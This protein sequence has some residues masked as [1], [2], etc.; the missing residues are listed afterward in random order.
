MKRILEACNGR[1]TICR[2]GYT[3]SDGERLLQ[4]LTLLLMMM[5]MV[6]IGLGQGLLLVS[7]FHMMRITIISIEIRACLAKVWE[8]MLWVGHWTKSPNHLLHTGLKVENFLCDSLS[9]Q[10][11]CTMVERTP[12]SMWATSTKEWLFSPRMKPWCVR[13]SHP[14]WGL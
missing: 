12:W 10:S 6:A 1:L 11:P 14:I 8:I 7:L 5:R 4:A 9:Q 13:C 2:E 3:A